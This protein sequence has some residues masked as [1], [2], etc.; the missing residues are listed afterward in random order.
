MDDLVEHAR[1]VAFALSDEEVHR[2]AST[3]TYGHRL[4]IRFNEFGRWVVDNRDAVG[5]SGF[6]DGHRVVG[7]LF[8]NPGGEL[9]LCV[10]HDRGCVTAASGEVDRDACDRLAL[11]LDVAADLVGH[12]GIDDIGLGGRCEPENTECQDQG[13]HCAREPTR[14]PSHC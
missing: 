2:C 13:T 1:D 6:I 14:V 9:T 5:K 3:G 11:V 10:R 12:F 8:R 4:H 7:F